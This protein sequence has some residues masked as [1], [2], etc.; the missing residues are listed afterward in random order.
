MQVGVQDGRKDKG[1]GQKK[2]NKVKKK[3]KKKTPST[4]RSTPQSQEDNIGAN[5]AHKAHRATDKH[6]F[7]LPL[8]Q[9]VCDTANAHHTINLSSFNPRLL[10]LLKGK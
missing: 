4:P 10:L 2:N 8:L 1:G 6:S 9:T 7:I 3:G 5:P